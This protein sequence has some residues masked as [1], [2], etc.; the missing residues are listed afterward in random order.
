MHDEFYLFRTENVRAFH[1]T[2]P[3]LDHGGGSLPW[4]LGRLPALE[5]LVL[6]EARLPRGSLSGLA[7]K[8]IPCPSL[9]TIAFFD[10]E[11]TGDVIRELGHIL[12]KRKDLTAS[13]LCRVVV[14]AKT[15]PLPD[16]KLIKQLRK[17]APYVVVGLGD[18]LPDR[19]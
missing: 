3:Q 4:A 17:S 1:L 19:L 6:S 13:E 12:M 14:V 15:R 11:M 5:V 10:C 9:R 8:P 7:K 18:E 2:A 16:F